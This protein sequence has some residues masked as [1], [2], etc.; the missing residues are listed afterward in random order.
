MTNFGHFQLEQ[1]DQEFR[2][3][4]GQHQLRATL[5]V[6]DFLEEGLDS[7]SH[8]HGLTRNHVFTR[9]KAFGVITQINGNTTAIHTLDQTGHHGAHA[10]TELIHDVSAFGLTHF[11]HDNLLRSLGGDTAECHGFQ[12]LFYIATGNG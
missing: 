7:I 5:L 1:L 9:N 4:T 8:A 6:T 2:R 3:S 11:L 12:R 10:I